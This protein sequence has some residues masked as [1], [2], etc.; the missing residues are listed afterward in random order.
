VLERRTEGTLATIAHTASWVLD[1]RGWW[2]A[3]KKGVGH[4]ALPGAAASSLG[5]FH[6]GSR[7]P[8]RS[9]RAL[10]PAWFLARF[11][12]SSPR[13]ARSLPHPP[14]PWPRPPPSQ[15]RRPAS[16]ATAAL[17]SRGC[18][19][20]ARKPCARSGRRIARTQARGPDRRGPGESV[21][22]LLYRRLL[23]GRVQ[24]GGGRVVWLHL[25]P[26]PPFHK[27][28]GFGRGAEGSR[29]G[30]AAAAAAAAEKAETAPLRSGASLGL[31]TWSGEQLRASFR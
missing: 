10:S 19:G 16:A 17:S 3:G 26:V 13:R 29:R 22:A 1:R 9:E 12:R 4:N 24:L 31:S 7:G 23:T 15:W 11:R 5:I 20:Q 6:L 8:G 27:T 18:R 14:L 30:A 21:R 28:L 25:H 2:C